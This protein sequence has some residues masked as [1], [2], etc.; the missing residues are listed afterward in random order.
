MA[1]YPGAFILNEVGTNKELTAYQNAPST[2]G[3]IKPRRKQA[4]RKRNQR[5]RVLLL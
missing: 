3:R 5:A 4:R 2:D 1:N